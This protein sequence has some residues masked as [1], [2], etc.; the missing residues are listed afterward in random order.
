MSLLG[1]VPPALIPVVLVLVPIGFLIRGLQ[2]RAAF[3]LL[4]MPAP[5]GAMI[6][7]SASSYATNKL[8]KVGGVAGV[9]SYL[10]EARHRGLR[11][12]Q[13]VGAYVA[14]RVSDTVALCAVIAAAVVI[15]SASGV[16]HGAL[17]V[18]AIAAFA[19]SLGLIGALV[20]M[21][22]SR[23]R[24]DVALAGP[25]W[26]VHRVRRRLGRAD[27]PADT[28]S[29]DD[30]FAAMVRLRADRRAHGPLL[31]TAIAG[32]LVGALSL[33]AVLMVAGINLGIATTL[34]VFVL[35]LLAAAVG[36]FPA[37]LGATEASLGALLVAQGVAGPS[38]AGAVIAFRVLDLWLPLAL[39]GLAVALR[40]HPTQPVPVD[41]AP[42]LAVAA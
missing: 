32:K 5:L 14:V 9:C 20:A 18:G 4:A 25:R 8:V 6:G 10:S 24:F 41:A 22:R 39:G 2:A 31:A 27:R 36:P 13:V 30:A 21:T 1:Q 3:K 42:T 26:L 33:Y 28:R 23:E 19:Y 11:R 40:A 38:A 12:S 35:T 37:G 7:M 29:S 16:L 34:V 15:G 17:L